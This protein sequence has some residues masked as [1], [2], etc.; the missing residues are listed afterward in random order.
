MGYNA[1]SSSA[2]S[3]TSTSTFCC[4]MGPPLLC[5]SV[6]C[7]VFGFQE[8]EQAVMPALAPETALLGAAE[9]RR[10]VGDD[11]PVEPDHAGLDPLAE[12]ERAAEVAA[13]DE[14]DQ[15]VLGVVGELDRLVLGR[16]RHHRRDR[17]EHLLGEDRAPGLH[18]VEDRGRIEEAGA[19]QPLAARAHA[20]AA[21]D[22]VADKSL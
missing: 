5:G 10:R 1:S 6:E 16:E 14:C 19:G 11:A 20:R 8:L 9:R 22:G 12:R 7:E 2:A 3:P 13:E 17:T 21:V 18:L 15:P 4:D